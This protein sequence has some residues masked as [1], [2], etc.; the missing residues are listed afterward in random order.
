MPRRD[1]MLTV[2]HIGNRI[3]LTV[4]HIWNRNNTLRY[5]T[6]RRDTPRY[7]TVRITL[8]YTLM[9]RLPTLRYTLMERLPTLGYTTVHIPPPKVHNGAYTLPEVQRERLPTLRA[10]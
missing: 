2:V 7:T 6:G 1:S 3:N 10:C 9:E 5:T 8:R 4:V